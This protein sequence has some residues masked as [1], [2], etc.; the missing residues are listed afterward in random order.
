MLAYTSWCKFNTGWY[1]SSRKLTPTG[2]E[3]TLTGVEIKNQ[4]GVNL[5]QHQG[6][7]INTRVFAVLGA[8]ERAMM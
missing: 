2:V 4:F 6:V 8:L 7:K 5:S 1:E 3:V